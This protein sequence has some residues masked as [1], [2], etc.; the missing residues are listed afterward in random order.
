MGPLPDA[1][2]L[3]PSLSPAL[4]VSLPLPL[5]RLYRTTHNNTGGDGGGCFRGETDTE[6][7]HEHKN[8]AFSGDTGSYRGQMFG[9]ELIATVYRKEG[10]GGG[11]E[12]PLRL[13]PPLHPRFLALLLVLIAVTRVESPYPSTRGSSRRG[14][15]FLLFFLPFSLE[16]RREVNAERREGKDGSLYFDSKQIRRTITGD[17]IEKK[18]NG[19]LTR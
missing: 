15:L 16:G 19:S 1:A 18:K 17:I 12:T 14:I 13:F 3:P 10:E 8:R 4:A 9:A 11:E 2:A 7:V 5:P 6:N